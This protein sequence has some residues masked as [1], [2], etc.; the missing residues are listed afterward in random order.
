MTA[1]TLQKSAKLTLKI[2]ILG[3]NSQL[4]RLFFRPDQ[5]PAVSL[6]K[7]ALSDRYL[8]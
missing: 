4:K 5:R 7:D 3:E 2:T 1:D 8:A 6:V